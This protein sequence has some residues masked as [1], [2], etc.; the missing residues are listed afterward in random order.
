MHIANHNYNSTYSNIV[1]MTFRPIWRTIKKK[2]LTANL[3]KNW[4]FDIT[5]IDMRRSFCPLLLWTLM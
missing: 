1:G 4:I 5:F 2:K 3:K